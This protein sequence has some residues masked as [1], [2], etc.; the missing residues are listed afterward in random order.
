MS[1]L[2]DDIQKHISWDVLNLSRKIKF[3]LNHLYCH[4]ELLM[5][6]LELLGLG[7]TARDGKGGH[8]HGFCILNPSHHL[9]KK[10]VLG[11]VSWFQF[12][13]C[14]ASVWKVASWTHCWSLIFLMLAR[15]SMS[16]ARSCENS[17]S[18]QGN[19]EEVC[20]ISGYLS[21][22]GNVSDYM[23]RHRNT[24]VGSLDFNRFPSLTP[25]VLH[26]YWLNLLPRLQPSRDKAR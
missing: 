7:E 14:V 18:Q 23:G 26:F 2:K 10:N 13:T 9:K 25:P 17:V 3:T 6:F 24:P 8:K 5:F 4:L 21:Y 15:S 22:R 16:T 11:N 12:L 20:L 1:G 19:L